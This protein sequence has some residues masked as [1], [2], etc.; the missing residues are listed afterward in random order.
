M[1]LIPVYTFLGVLVMPLTCRYR[2]IFSA[3]MR[4][5]SGGLVVRASD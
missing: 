5:S 2:I 3:P 1:F 4:K